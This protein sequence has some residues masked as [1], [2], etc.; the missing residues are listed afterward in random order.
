LKKSFCADSS[1]QEFHKKYF[2]DVTME[3]WNDWRWQLNH[4]LMECS[5][6]ERIFDLS[7]SERMA[8]NRGGEHTLPVA[9]TPYYAGVIHAGGA[10]SPLRV[11]HVPVLEE[12]VREPGE[13]GDPLGEEG[14]T[15][16]PG[17]IH[18]YPD[19]VLYLTT[20]VCATYC[21]FC[22]RSRMVGHAWAGGNGGTAPKAHTDPK[23]RWEQA[24]A[25]IADH[26][27]IR[28]VVLSGGDV[29]T[30][31]D[32]RLNWLL[33]RLRAIPHV[34]ILR[35]G[36]KVPAVLPMRIT[37]RLTRM[38]K[39]YHPLWIS[40]HVTHPDELTNEFTE[41]TTRLAD[42][43]I[44]LGSQTVLLAGVNDDVATMT[45]LMQGL[46]RCRVK[47]YYIYQCDPIYGSGHFRTPVERG[48]EI[49]RGLRG[50]TSGYAVPTY[51]ID[52]PGGGGKIPMQ[53]AYVTGRDGAD[54]LLTNYEGRSFRYPQSHV[55]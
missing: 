17:L 51:V 39:R 7:D 34:E 33:D 20:P 44:P 18:R 1:L 12:F 6:L 48:L 30:L 13:S 3:D 40:L 29:L 35:L 38:L 53:P 55:A 43:G 42:A 54:W 2:A 41:A 27:S 23:V 31:P 28:D 45:R 8:L 25:Y 22:T 46:M 10:A 26:P 24:I 16:V 32:E 5:E 4:R 14:H 11:T 49:I 19:R 15:A 37:K 36:T 21:R 50:H 52:A 47:P 9:L